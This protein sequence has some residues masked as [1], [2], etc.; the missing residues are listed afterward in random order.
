MNKIFFSA[1]F[2]CTT[3]CKSYAIPDKNLSKDE[4]MTLLGKD[5]TLQ[6]SDGF[7]VKIF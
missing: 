6:I 2:L 7:G 3:L 4:K 1:L 5:H